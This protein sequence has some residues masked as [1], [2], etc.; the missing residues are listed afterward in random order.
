MNLVSSCI[1]S[2]VTY[3]LDGVIEEVRFYL[4]LKH[5]HLSPLKGLFLLHESVDQ[6]VNVID[7]VVVVAL[8]HVKLAAT[9]L[10]VDFLKFARSPVFLHGRGE[11]EHRIGYVPADKRACK[12]R[13]N[14]E[15][16]KHKYQDVYRGKRH[17]LVAVS[18]DLK[19]NYR[20]IS[21]SATGSKSLFAVN[22]YILV[23]N[24]F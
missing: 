2:H 5:T 17:H 10:N 18:R 15:N 23:D 14:N 22:C 3:G 12:E 6:L 8:K 1:Q 16:G 7:H 24:V 4:L 11:L 20:H 19:Q 13:Q 21:D 9:D